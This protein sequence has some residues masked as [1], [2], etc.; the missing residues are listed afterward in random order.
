MKPAGTEKWKD[1]NSNAYI[2]EAWDR[3]RV[4]SEIYILVSALLSLK[5]LLF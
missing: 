5:P 1:K 4:K 3:V 2:T